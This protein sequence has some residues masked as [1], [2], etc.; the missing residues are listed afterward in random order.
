MT[1]PSNRKTA[2]PPHAA[3]LIGA[4]RYPNKTQSSAEL[5]VPALTLQGALI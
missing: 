1:N 5:I 2:Q 3:A 4:P